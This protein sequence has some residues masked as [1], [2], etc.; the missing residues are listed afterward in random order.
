MPIVILVFGFIHDFTV[1]FL[2]VKWISIVPIVKILILS[3]LLRIFVSLIDSLFMAVG[4]SKYSSFIQ[5]GRLFVFAVLALPCGY[6][7]GITGIALSALLSLVAI[8]IYFL[9]IVSIRLNIKIQEVKENIL[10][11]VIFG[12]TM[13]GLLYLTKNIYYKESIVFFVSFIILTV[14]TYI[15]AGM[16]LNKYTELKFFAKPISIFKSFV[17]FK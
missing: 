2:G 5:S 6:F 4:E 1:L 7:W 3:G 13:I 8:F 17:F 11:P 15:L 14:I 16:A 9:K 12:L 10:L